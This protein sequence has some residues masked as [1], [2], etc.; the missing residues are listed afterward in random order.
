MV[1]V[2]TRMLKGQPY[3]EAARALGAAGLEVVIRHVLRQI[4]PMLGMLF[5]FE[6]GATLMMVAGLGFLGY[7]FGGAFWIEITDFS[8]RATS[9]RPELGQML[10]NS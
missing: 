10:A 6:T 3:V 8:A 1:S 2:Q 4:T 9:G 7:Y 5:A